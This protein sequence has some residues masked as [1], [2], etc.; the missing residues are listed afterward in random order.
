MI[1]KKLN[2]IGP[3]LKRLRIWRGLS[4]SDLSDKL[5]LLGWKIS[6]DSIGHMEI[7]TKRITDC[8]LIFFA[9][10]LNVKIA[11][12]F[13][14]TFSQQELRPRIKS[15]RLIKVPLQNVRQVK[16]TRRFNLN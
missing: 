8:D 13:P 4:Q 14:T 5:R 15:N 10:A 1:P 16:T 9:K 3:Q 6:R 11:D 12:F 7:T 2:I